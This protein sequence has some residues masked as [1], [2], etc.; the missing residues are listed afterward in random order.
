LITK[1]I[2][3]EK[4]DVI[5]IIGLLEFIDNEEIESILDMLYNLLNKNGKLIITTPNYT[6][7]MYLLEKLLNLLGPINYK[8]QHINRFNVKSL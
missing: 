4:Y 5:T 3:H 2:K 6:I 7:S 8:N 1:K